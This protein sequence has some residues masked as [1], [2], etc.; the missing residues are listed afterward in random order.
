MEKRKLL[1]LPG[2]GTHRSAL[3]KQK[4]CFKSLDIPLEILVD[5]IVSKSLEK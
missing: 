4:I 5:V 1:A 3:M 2:L